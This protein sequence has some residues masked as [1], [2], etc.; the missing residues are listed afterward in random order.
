MLSS[1]VNRTLVLFTRAPTTKGALIMSAA[2]HAPKL[3]GKLKPSFI[4]FGSFFFGTNTP[5]Q[6]VRDFW[7][8]GRRILS[9][10]DDM[11]TGGF[12]HTDDGLSVTGPRSSV[13]IQCEA[14]LEHSGTLITP[15]APARRSEAQHKGLKRDYSPFTIH[16]LP[17]DIRRVGTAF[18]PT[19]FLRLLRRYA[20][21]ASAS[22]RLALH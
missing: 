22:W 20:R 2:T 12:L 5:G 13:S 1:M 15:A 21:G 19:I 3:S 14:S 10:Q 11:Q 7:M 9:F 4:R 16:D 8:D 17:E 18:V 6:P